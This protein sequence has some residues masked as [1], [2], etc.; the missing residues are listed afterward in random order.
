MILKLSLCLT[1]FQELCYYLFQLSVS[2]TWEKKNLERWIIK[3]GL[4][5]QDLR[6]RIFYLF[7]FS[8]NTSCLFSLANW[9][10]WIHITHL[11]VFIYTKKTWNTK[12]PSMPLSC[13]Q[14]KLRRRWT[15]LLYCMILSLNEYC[16]CLSDANVTLAEYELRHQQSDWIKQGEA[17]MHESKPG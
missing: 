11:R 15:W 6:W 2:M 5:Q 8:L 4:E 12:I 10:G 16:A 14:D 17:G 9:L 1:M 3:I 7:E 13:S